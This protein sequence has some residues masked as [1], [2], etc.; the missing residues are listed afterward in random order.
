MPTSPT[1]AD[2]PADQLRARLRAAA[3]RALESLDN[4]IADHQDPG[5]EALGARYELARELSNTSPEVARQLLGT[6]ETAAPVVDEQEPVQLR[7]G[8]DDVMYGDDDTTTLLLSGPGREPYWVELDPERTAALRDALAGPAAPPAPLAEV[9]TVWAEDESTLG[10]YSDEVTAKLAAIEY[11]QETET[12]GL[13]FVYGWNEHGG[14]LELLADGGDTG[15]RVKRDPVYAAP[16]APA[17]RAATS[18]PTVLAELV[19]TIRDLQALQQPL[20]DAL[21]HIREDMH[22]ARR[23]GDE[24]AMEWM[25]DVWAELPLAV[26]AAGG[27]EDAVHELAAAGV[28]PP[29]TTDPDRRNELLDEWLAIRDQATEWDARRWGFDPDRWCEIERAAMQR[30]ADTEGAR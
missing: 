19:G 15:L 26:R 11:H 18:S 16:P 23:C 12:P 27:D 20:V 21:R 14:R 4:L 28:Q 10:H 13:E 7:W 22:R 29:T 5:A 9:W 1:P 8:L 17:D 30:R 24:W 2:R 25:S 6:T 3:Q